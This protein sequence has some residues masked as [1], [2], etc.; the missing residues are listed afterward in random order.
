MDWNNNPASRYR[1]VE[2][3]LAGLLTSVLVWLHFQVLTH[4]GALWRDEISSLR[5]AT[6]PTLSD[7][8][9][10]L[11][12]DPFPAFYFVVLRSWSALGLAG[13]D[14]DLRLL[15]FLTGLLLIGS[16]W[17]AAWKINRSAPLWPLALFSFN[18]ITLQF[19]DSLRAYGTGLIWS[20]LAFLFVWRLTFRSAN[21][22][23]FAFAAA[24]S[25][26]AVQTIFTN[27]LSILAICAG[28]AVICVRRKAW[29]RVALILG[30]GAGAAISLVPYSGIFRQTG[31]WSELCATPTSYDD[32]ATMFWRAIGQGNISAGYVWCALALT[33]V[34]L[35]AWH[36]VPGGKLRANSESEGHLVFAVVVLIAAILGTFTFFRVVRWPTSLWYF[37][38][39]MGTAALCLHIIGT[40]VIRVVNLKV[41]FPVGVAALIAFALPT[42]TR[43][44]SAR[45][46]NCDLMAEAIAQQAGKDDLVVVNPYFYGISF[47]RYYRGVAPWTTLPP[48]SDRSLHRWDLLK[49]A[50]E[51]PDPMRELLERINATLKAG[52]YVFLVGGL[53]TDGKSEPAILAPAPQTDAG[54][55]LRAYTTNWARRT[56]WTVKTHAT[57]GVYYLVGESNPQVPYEYVQTYAVRGWKDENVVAAK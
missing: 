4:A 53:P 20:T 32:I 55:A 44:A 50:M 37:L 45:L 43:Y 7:F 14:F 49:E 27:S 5:L 51:D 38:P 33:G 46:T 19:G 54:W 17:F 31:R 34:L 39:L 57:H 10:S 23:T 41:V 1:Y 18:P 21:W 36:L 56:W 28:G 16:I 52:H 48:V 26:L 25:I 22:K 13:T 24:T 2:F 6:M 12:Y 8:W 3:G 29:R 42:T 15:G 9:S 35:A 30:A 11:V 47:Q 40:M